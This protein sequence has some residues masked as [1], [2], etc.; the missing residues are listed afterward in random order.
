MSVGLGDGA[1]W[2]NKDIDPIEMIEIISK[3]WIKRM[4]I[5]QEIKNNVKFSKE[6]GYINVELLLNLL[7]DRREVL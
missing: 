6:Q 4:E 7:K 1:N 3:V 2:K 5:K